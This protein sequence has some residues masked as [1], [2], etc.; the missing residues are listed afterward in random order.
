M[1]LQH[2]LRH[3]PVAPPRKDDAHAV[4]VQLVLATLKSPLVEV[5]EVTHLVDGST[6]VLGRERV[7][8]EGLHPK[9]QR[10]VGRVDEGLLARPVTLRA[11]EAP[12]AGPSG[13]CR[14]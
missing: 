4:G 9:C 10:P 8:R 1:F 2:A 3:A 13:R 11:R 6:P 14:P 7:D 12:G 5:H